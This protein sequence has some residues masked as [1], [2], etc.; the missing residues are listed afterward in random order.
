MLNSPMA[1]MLYSVGQNRRTVMTDR[2]RKVQTLRRK[3]PGC[4]ELFMQGV[5]QHVLL[6]ISIFDTEKK[7]WS[8]ELELESGGGRKLE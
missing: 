1:P 8:N 3:P 4:K 5:N 6:R 7:S 2:I